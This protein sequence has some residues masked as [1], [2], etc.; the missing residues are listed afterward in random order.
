MTGAEEI[1][2]PQILALGMT[3]NPVSWLHFESRL[4]Y[5]LGFV[6]SDSGFGVGLVVPKLPGIDAQ[7]L[8]LCEAYATPAQAA[9]S[10]DN[11]NDNDDHEH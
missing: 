4:L 11:D 3:Q 8:A 2:H 1:L 10:I 6:L 9:A 5:D 7:L